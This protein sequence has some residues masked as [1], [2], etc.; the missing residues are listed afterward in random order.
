MTHPYVSYQRFPHQTLQK[1]QE[2]PSISQ[3]CEH[4]LNWGLPTLQKKIKAVT[5]FKQKIPHKKHFFIF[6]FQFILF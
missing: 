6:I 2:L 1:V 4:I 3:I 5:V